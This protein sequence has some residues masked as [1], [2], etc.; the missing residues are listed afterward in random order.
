MLTQVDVKRLPSYQLGYED[1]E[2]RGAAR[3]EARG[4]ANTQRHV[5]RQLLAQ[6]D[7]SRVA[8][9]LGLDIAEVQRIAAAQDGDAAR[10]DQQPD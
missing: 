8:E 9:L 10:Q 5:V 2:A 7:A 1:G 3:G 6:L 4:A